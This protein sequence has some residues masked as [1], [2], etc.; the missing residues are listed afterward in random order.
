MRHYNADIETA[1]DSAE[2][3]A[4][5]GKEPKLQIEM[6]PYSGGYAPDFSFEGDVIYTMPSTQDPHEFHLNYKNGGQKC[7][8]IGSHTSKNEYGMQVYL[9]ESGRWTYDNGTAGPFTNVYFYYN[10]VKCRIIVYS[11]D[12]D[13]EINGVK[14]N[15][16]LTFPSY[17][18]Y[19]D[20]GTASACVIGQYVVATVSFVKSSGLYGYALLYDGTKWSNYS[21]FAKTLSSNRYLKSCD[22]R[23]SI[24]DGN[25]VFSLSYKF[26]NGTSS[27]GWKR[28]IK[29]IPASI[30]G[31]AIVTGNAITI[32]EDN[33]PGGRENREP[34]IFKHG[35]NYFVPFVRT[36]VDTSTP[37]R[38]YCITLKGNNLADALLNPS[39]PY[40]VIDYPVYHIDSITDQNESTAGT[41][42][43]AY[44]DSNS[45]GANV[46]YKELAPITVPAPDPFDDTDPTQ[47]IDSLTM[48]ETNGSP[49]VQL[50]GTLVN[51]SPKMLRLFH[52]SARFALRFGM[53]NSA[54]EYLGVFYVDEV[55]YNAMSATMSFSARNSIGFLLM[56]GNYGKKITA[57]GGLRD[58]IETLIKFANIENYTID[59]ALTNLSTSITF[60]G[61]SL[62]DN[63]TKDILSKYSIDGE[64]LISIWERPNGEVLIGGNK[65]MKTNFN[66][67]E[68]VTLNKGNIFMRSIKMGCD[69]N[70]AA[71]ALVSSDSSYTYN[72]EVP[73]NGWKVPRKIFSSTG[74][75]ASSQA[76][77]DAIG[78]GLVA[79]YQN[80]GITT[81]WNAPFNPRLTVGDIVD[82]ADNGGTERAGLVTS[83]T[84]TMG[85]KGF[86]TAFT[87]DSGG[88][89]DNEVTR[90]RSEYG[91]TSKQTIVD[92]VRKVAG[93]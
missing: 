74:Y 83:V 75:S 66:P 50:S 31:D 39:E 93:K 82:F 61:S 40:Q 4:A 36:A 87:T 56:G 8:G 18:T 53:G 44:L 58:G 84:H 64:P 33:G 28:G 81:S 67:A 13:A 27:S 47:F 88:V 79:E 38:A 37:N 35:S 29:I 89:I 52:P 62:Y 6:L 15:S 23:V 91:Y 20:L 9:S 7:I 5:A 90:T 54:K 42:A 71:V 10:G 22:L 2:Q 34:S 21:I 3:T 46:Y 1:L 76:D 57:T 30:V 69:T 32:F 11:G 45:G 16:I 25:P 17:I 12:V 92:L 70:I 68:V 85:R 43:I 60:G 63:I 24:V 51:A 19:G 73:N 77:L 80:Y 86:S 72:K 26:N 55:N 78:D 14:E 65:W 48:T 41:V 49:V 59:P